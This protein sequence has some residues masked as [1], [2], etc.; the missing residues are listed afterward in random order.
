MLV[1]AFGIINKKLELQS[2]LEELD[3]QSFSKLYDIRGP[4]IVQK[5]TIDLAF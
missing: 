5:K 4:T 3:L 2:F 1:V